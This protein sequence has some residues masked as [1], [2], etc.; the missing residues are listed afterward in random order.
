MA[1]TTDSPSAQE[2]LEFY[3]KNFGAQGFRFTYKEGRYLGTKGD[4]VI[5]MTRAPRIDSA[6]AYIEKSQEAPTSL[7]GASDIFSDLE[8]YSFE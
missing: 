5:Y 4:E 2:L 8:N 6:I 7:R 1:T 3:L